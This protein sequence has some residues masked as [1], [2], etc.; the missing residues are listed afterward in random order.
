M[1]VMIF[2]S[3]TLIPT[4]QTQNMRMIVTKI[5][6]LRFNKVCTTLVTSAQNIVHCTV[7]LIPKSQSIIS[8]IEY[9]IV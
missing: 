2:I 7:N 4:T 9:I 6:I 8:R 3:S 5:A 1:L